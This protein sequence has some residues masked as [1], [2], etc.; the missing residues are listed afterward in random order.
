VEKKRCVLLEV[1]SEV[2]PAPGVWNSTTFNCIPLPPGLSGHGSAR[3]R[4][5]Q[6]IESIHTRQLVAKHHAQDLFALP[7]QLA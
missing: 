2:M 7:G 4:L 1:R 5:R 6:S 3:T